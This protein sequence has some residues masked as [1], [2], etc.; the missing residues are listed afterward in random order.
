MNNQQ[1]WQSVL[2]NIEVSLSKANFT[3]WFKNTSILEKNND[4]IIVAVPNSFTKEWLQNKYSTE[5]LKTLRAV[6]PEVR[7]I[8]YQVLGAGSIQSQSQAQQ[9]AKGQ[10]T[11]RVAPGTTSTIA[12]SALNNG[13][14]PRYVFDTFIVGKNNELAHAAALAVSQ[15]PGTIYNPLFIYGGVGLGKT[16]LMQAIGHRVQESNPGARILYISSERF[17]NE[18]VQALGQGRIPQFKDLYRNVDVLMIDD[19]QFL[20]GKESTQEEF[21]HTFNTLHQNNKQVILSSD[22]LPKDIP[23]IEERLVSRFA[24]G[25]IADIQAPDFETRLAILKTKCKE[26]N[27]DVNNEVLTYIAEV[28]QSNIREL[29][30]AL[31]RMIVYCQ[32]NNISPSV[33]LAKTVLAGV[34][35][36]KKKV[37]SPRKIMEAVSDFYNISLDDLLRQSRRKEF[38][39][40][41]QIAMY[42]MRIELE[43]SFPSIGDHFNGRD[44]TTVMHAVDKIKKLI[45]EK[46]SMKQEIDLIVNK[47]YM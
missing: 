16:H 5:I 33:D 34:A 9:P 40:P 38:V 36:Q 24:W 15:R 37:L 27:Y 41:R 18:F 20:A 43:N 11:A 32:L 47:L 21:F 25:M 3:T 30:G 22:R 42:L 17:T 2:G 29:E 35:S 46:E 26:K 14:N 19:I 1:L 4:Y 31:N 8:R 39:K 7:E 45:V 23:A 12:P 10:E 13:L 6:A 44:H 28:V